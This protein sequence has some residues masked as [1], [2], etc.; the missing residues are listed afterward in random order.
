MVYDEFFWFGVSF[1]FPEGTDVSYFVCCVVSQWRVKAPCYDPISRLKCDLRVFVVS[2]V[3]KIENVHLKEDQFMK[4]SGAT[5][6]VPLRINKFK[7][8]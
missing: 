6:L 3:D 7:Q 8:P 1:S 5:F 2:L 4:I